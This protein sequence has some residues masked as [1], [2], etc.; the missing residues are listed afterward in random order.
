MF[1]K[2]SPAGQRIAQAMRA[3]SGMELLRWCDDME[4]EAARVTRL[5]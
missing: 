5:N 3:Y 2:L 4:A 1:A